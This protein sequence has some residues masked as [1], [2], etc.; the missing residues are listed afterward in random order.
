[1]SCRRST[2]VVAFS[3]RLV[4][5]LESPGESPGWTLFSWDDSTFEMKQLSSLLLVTGIAKACGLPQA[6][7]DDLL[8]KNAR[9]EAKVSELQE[10]LADLA[11]ESDAPLV[12]LAS[13]EARELVSAHTGQRY[14]IKVKLP[15]SYQKGDATYPVL[16]VVDAETNF[17]GVSYIAQRLIKDRLIPEIL[18]VG[19]AYGTDYESFYQLRS[20]DLTPTEDEDSTIGHGNSPDPTGGGPLFARFLAEELF[21]FVESEY[22]ARAHGRAFYGHSYGGLFGSW[23]ILRHPDLFR[24]YLLLSPSLWFDDRVLLGEVS[25][26]ELGDQASRLYM[27]SGRLE[28]RIDDLQ[29]EFVAALRRLRSPQLEIRSEVLDDETHRT[30]FGRGFT[31]GLRFLY[32]GGM[33][34]E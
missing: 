11:A 33:Q 16:Y 29:I 4:S 32:S 24:R 30:V 22:R 15:R 31:N 27:A 20:R 13:T 8:L 25:E 18:V 12:V 14:Q 9:L 26:V 19:V 23:L 21:P 1:M 28:P 5:G 17:G 7:S 10:R 6:S 3:P 34:S 2:T